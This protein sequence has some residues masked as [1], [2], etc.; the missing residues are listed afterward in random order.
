MTPEMTDWL[1]LAVKIG[2]TAL[3]VIAVTVAAERAGALAGA[4][5]AT[6]PTVP[7]P[8]F[9]LLALDHGASFI[10][11]AATFALAANSMSA[12]FAAVYVVLAQR[13]SLWVCMAAATLWWI[14]GTGI[15]THFDFSPLAAALLTF[16]VLVACFFVVRPYREATIPR[17]PLRPVDIVI[18]GVFAAAMAAIIL[19]AGEHI[20][21]SWAGALS[22]FPVM[23]GSIAILLHPRLG[24]HAAASV[25]ANANIGMF[26]FA[27][28]A[29]TVAAMAMRIGS[30]PALALA[31]AV[32]IG[33]N[34]AMFFLRRYQLAQSSL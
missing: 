30:F 28:C 19:L 8:V 31:L 12:S 25:I 34:V 18:R 29:L 4:L 20:G 15:V 2:L 9:V 33:W 21:S 11:N 16:S 13:N 6:L 1:L 24:G 27:L 10:A 3:A 17:L 5:L 26:G 7:G 14:V 23:F 32:S 22:V